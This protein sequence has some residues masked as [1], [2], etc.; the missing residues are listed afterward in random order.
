[1]KK[2]FLFFLCAAALC[3]PT[4]ADESSFFTDYNEQEYLYYEQY[5]EQ[6][7]AVCVAMKLPRDITHAII[8]LLVHKAEQE[9]TTVSYSEDEIK[10]EV[11]A[12][13]KKLAVFA[14]WYQKYKQSGSA[15][16]FVTWLQEYIQN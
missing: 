2:F 16:D 8:A 5:E 11:S 1:M 15:Q 13:F 7:H 10:A 3:P 12:T 9:K 4:Q 6:L 14:Y